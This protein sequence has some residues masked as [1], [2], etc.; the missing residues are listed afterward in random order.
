MN[1]QDAVEEDAVEELEEWEI[2]E[3]GRPARECLR[4]EADDDDEEPEHGDN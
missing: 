2:C 1:E 3:C 4:Y